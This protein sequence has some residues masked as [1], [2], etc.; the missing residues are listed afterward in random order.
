MRTRPATRNPALTTL[1]HGPPTAA[2]PDP[3][4]T[5]HPFNHKQ[6][7]RCDVSLASNPYSPP[8]PRISLPPPL[9]SLALSYPN[10]SMTSPAHRSNA[11]AS[12]PVH[13]NVLLTLSGLLSSTT[14]PKLSRI[15]Q[16]NESSAGRP[17]QRTIRKTSA[18][19]ALSRDMLS[20]RVPSICSRP[21]IISE[22]FSAQSHA[23]FSS[24]LLARIG[25]LNR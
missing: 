6:S 4:T 23:I 17:L 18:G 8:Y 21:V 2:S 25:G 16:S 3:T 11:L 9:P 24:L 22:F 10:A 13:H 7:H 14:V 12:S 1:I 20:L 5:P 19:L 15:T